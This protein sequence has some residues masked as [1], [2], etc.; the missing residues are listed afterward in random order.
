ML[1]VR[2]YAKNV[3]FS[4]NFTQK[5]NFESI[6]V[7]SKCKRMKNWFKCEQFT[8]VLKKTL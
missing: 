7:V 1:T 2:L 8:M 6:L 5:L 4:S 3:P